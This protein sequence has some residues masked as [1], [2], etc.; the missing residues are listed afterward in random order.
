MFAGP[1]AFAS[2]RPV[3]PDG[4]EVLLVDG[5]G[6]LLSMSL[7]DGH[8]RTVASSSSGAVWSPD[9]RWIARYDGLLARDGTV[10]REGFSGLLWSPDSAQ[11]AT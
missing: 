8:V 1:V 4:Q 10:V 3:S 2:E 7:V 5:G 6:V 11:L 9:G